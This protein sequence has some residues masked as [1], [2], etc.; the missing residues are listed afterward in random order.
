MQNEIQENDKPTEVVEKL[1]ERGLVSEEDKEPALMVLTW[2]KQG[3]EA[4]EN[5]SKK[6]YNQLI[7]SGFVDSENK[8]IAGPNGPDALWFMMALEGAKG[9][10]DVHEMVTPGLG[11]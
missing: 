3:P 5:V 4:A 10:L 6:Y 8:L 11:K 9:E 2:A 7:E 1:I